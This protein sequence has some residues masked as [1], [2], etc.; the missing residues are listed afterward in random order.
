MD[1]RWYTES[2]KENFQ[3]R[4]RIKNVLLVMNHILDRKFCSESSSAQ[5]FHVLSSQILI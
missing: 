4:I 3:D 5:E 1:Y 2:Q